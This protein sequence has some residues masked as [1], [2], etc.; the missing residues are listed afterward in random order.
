MRGL[1]GG[2]F[3]QADLLFATQSGAALVVILFSD[4]FRRASLNRVT[5][6]G[7]TYRAKK[8]LS[9]PGG[10]RFHFFRSMWLMKVGSV[11]RA[12]LI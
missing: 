1:D 9:F 4:D 6:T 10:R 7:G 8:S 5:F 3:F 12:E 11:G 2:F